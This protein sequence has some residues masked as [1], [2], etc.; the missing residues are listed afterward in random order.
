MSNPNHNQAEAKFPHNQADSSYYSGEPQ[1]E[2]VSDAF[3]IKAVLHETLLALL[4]K[5]FRLECPPE[6][7]VR[8]YQQLLEKALQPAVRHKSWEATFLELSILQ[9]EELVLT[10]IQRAISSSADTTPASPIDAWLTTLMTLEDV[11]T[12]QSETLIHT[13]L[14]LLAM[15]HQGGQHGERFKCATSDIKSLRDVLGFEG[16]NTQYFDLLPLGTSQEI[17]LC[18]W[19]SRRLQVVLPWGQLLQLLPE[20][21]KSNTTAPRWQ[22]LHR[23]KQIYVLLENHPFFK[24]TPCRPEYLQ[25]GLEKLKAL[26]LDAFRQVEKNLGLSWPLSVLVLVEGN[27]EVLVLPAIS[28][29]L[30]IDFAQ[31]GI[32]ILPVGGKS[33]MLNA[34]LRFTEI[35][36]VPVVVMLDQDAAPL[37]PDLEY[38]R[39]PKDKILLL[40]GEIE[41]TYSEELIE[42]TIR[43]FYYAELAE[44]SLTDSIGPTETSTTTV[45][46]L[47]RFWTEHGLGR[48]NKITFATQL[49]QV[50]VSEQMVSPAMKAVIEH[51]LEAK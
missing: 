19:L 6:R 18:Y 44:F 15:Y 30:G 26:K 36:N 49:S 48:F 41:D 45:S 5:I 16:F 23:L 4:N 40:S 9:Q 39:R 2:G 10:C 29:T 35:L 42:K 8:R 25:E 3:R 12:Y 32:E 27:T 7:N 20:L 47:E 50:L 28:K 51:I 17:S 21:T 38:Y 43:Q 33:Q 1:T 14:A 22:S 24:T 34:F 37:K 46:A 11:E 13:D 31:E